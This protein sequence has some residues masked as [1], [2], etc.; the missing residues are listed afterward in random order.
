MSAQKKELELY[1]FGRV[2]T[3]D[4]GKTIFSARPSLYPI[5]SGLSLLYVDSKM[6]GGEGVLHVE[7]SVSS[8]GFGAYLQL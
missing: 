6:K 2:I 4:F 5:L 1:P 7:K 3:L 8:I